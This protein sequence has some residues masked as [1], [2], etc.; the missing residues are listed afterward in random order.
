MHENPILAPSALRQL[1]RYDHESGKLFW[2]VRDGTVLPETQRA[3][4]S[5]NKKFAGKEAGSICASDGYIYIGILGKKYAAHRAIWAICYGEWPNIIDH[6]NHVRTDNKI[7]NL[8]NVNHRENR[9]NY[10][11]SKPT[12]SGHF[13]V[14]FHAPSNLWM[15]RI[16]VGQRHMKL[17]GYFKTAEA[18]IVVRKAAEIEYGYHPNHKRLP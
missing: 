6:Q 8:R 4:R 12:A 2:L 18:A 14:T 16:G 13:G 7:S 9:K 11:V 17:L 1:L 10:Q 15:A 5:F 3:Y